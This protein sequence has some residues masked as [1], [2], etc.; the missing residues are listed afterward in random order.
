MYTLDYCLEPSYSTSL[1]N[2]LQLNTQAA[3]ISSLQWTLC[4]C[5]YHLSENLSGIYTWEPTC[6]V[7]KHTLP[8]P[9]DTEALEHGSPC[10]HLH[11]QC[12][13]SLY[14]HTS[15][16]LPTLLALALNRCEATSHCYTIS[17]S[18]RTNDWASLH[19][20]NLLCL[21][22]CEFLD[23]VLCLLFSWVTS[24]I[25]LVD[26]QEFLVYSRYC[27]RSIYLLQIST[28]NLSSDFF[29]VRGVFY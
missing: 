15:S 2:P 8:F 1:S 25:S 20:L 23:H 13:K 22:F 29:L 18:L 16:S 17:I 4:T 11:Y 24:V 7:V 6:W 28:V 26:L 12:L 19:V 9:D 27:S 3:S 21:S 5:V 10:P 14:P